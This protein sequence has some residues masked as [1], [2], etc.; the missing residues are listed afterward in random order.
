MDAPSKAR[1]DSVLVGGL[2]AG[3]LA[4]LNAATVD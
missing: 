3:A 4:F 1:P 2:I